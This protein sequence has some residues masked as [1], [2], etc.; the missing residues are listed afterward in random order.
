[1]LLMVALLAGCQKFAEFP[2]LSADEMRRFSATLPYMQ[3]VYGDTAINY[4]TIQ[5]IVN[6]GDTNV[7]RHSITIYGLDQRY[8]IAI[9]M[10][11]DTLPTGDFS[12]DARQ[13]S[14]SIFQ[15]GQY[16]IGSLCPFCFFDLNV[17]GVAT[18]GV[19]GQFSGSLKN[20]LTGRVL[21]VEGSF[22]N[23]RSN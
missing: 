21:P 14:V 19:Q 22:I 1:M 9:T 20:P 17:A 12:L 5:T 15:Y 13:G 10:P 4:F 6:A 2:S 18:G 8:S 7:T 11:G 23:I 3:V 16:E